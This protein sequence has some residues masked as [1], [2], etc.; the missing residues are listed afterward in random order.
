MKPSTP[1]HFTVFEKQFPDFDGSLIDRAW[2]D[3][4]RELGYPPELIDQIATYQREAIQSETR[5]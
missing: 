1:A 4:V 5:R 2:L 3:V